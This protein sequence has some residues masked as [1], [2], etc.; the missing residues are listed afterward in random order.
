MASLTDI[1]NILVGLPS[2]IWSKVVW[3]KDKFIEEFKYQREHYF[4]NWLPDTFDH[5]SSTYSWTKGHI[6]DSVD[7][8]IAAV[9]RWSD[10]S[11][12]FFG[13]WFTDVFNQVSATYGWTK[14]HITDMKD[15]VLGRLPDLEL[16]IKT[17]VHEIGTG[18]DTA[19]DLAKT[20]INEYI[21]EVKEGLE[22]TMEVVGD[23]VGTSLDKLPEGFKTVFEGLS[24]PFIEAFNPLMAAVMKY[25]EKS[26]DIEELKEDPGLVEK[27]LSSF[28]K[29]ES[30]A[31][32]GEFHEIAH[33]SMVD[34]ETAHSEAWDLR[35]KV[36]AAKIGLYVIGIVAEIASAGQIEGVTDAVR[37]FVEGSAWDQVATEIPMIEYEAKLLKPLRYYYNREF[38]PEIPGMGDLVHFRVKE[39]ITQEE[40]VEFALLQG[41]A[42]RYSD[43]Y[44]DAHWLLPS[45]GQAYDMEAR[46]EITVPELEELLTFADFD[47][48]YRAQMMAIR[49]TLP[50][51][52]DLRRMY[53][54]GDIDF[55]TM[56]KRMRHRGYSE[57]DA[58]LVAKAQAWETMSSNIG[59]LMTNLKNDLK[60]GWI[61]EDE[62]KAGLM[63][64]GI[65]DLVREY[66]ISDG[67]ADR[68]REE[69]EELK[70]A[71]I[72]AF[73]KDLMDSSELSDRLAVIGLEPWKVQSILAQEL[74]KKGEWPFE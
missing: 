9:G 67:L 56:A 43:A 51:R 39:A 29:A 54:A 40:F 57:D 25:T 16:A 3:L 62:Y 44:W 68:D 31:G 34:P 23:S 15:E 65:P 50:G 37:G 11:Q 47:P 24:G 69:L 55:S 66:Q 72:Q 5:I 17:K 32:F 59:L 48:R 64:L 53:E 63:E 20:G 18:M 49:F 36:F 14:G 1:F 26:N 41:Y 33:E 45:P 73:R 60:R 22:N 71:L 4:D 6:L 52:V 7:D 61:S 38:T 74:I 28:T 46:G 30:E 19:L 12:N 8:T 70:G 21:G 13:P 58:E 42:Q 2:Y 10:L 35:K 27:L